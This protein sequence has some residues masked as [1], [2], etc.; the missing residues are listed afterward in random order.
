MK[1]TRFL[2]FFCCFLVNLQTVFANNTDTDTNTSHTTHSP[3]TVMGFQEDSSKPTAEN[4]LVILE[5]DHADVSLKSHQKWNIYNQPIRNCVQ[6]DTIIPVQNNKIL[7]FLFDNAIDLSA[8]VTMS[9]LGYKKKGCT[10]HFIQGNQ[11]RTCLLNKKLLAIFM[12]SLLNPNVFDVNS[13]DAQ[14]I[15]LACKQ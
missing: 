11:K 8:N 5:P 3:T 7:A 4:N 6:G 1:S 14:K 2:V 13:P 9:V 15:L 12:D 10:V